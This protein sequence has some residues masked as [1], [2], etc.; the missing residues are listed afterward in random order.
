MLVRRNCTAAIC[1]ALLV[2]L[3]PLS[4]ALAGDRAHAGGFF[5]RLSG[6]VG[7]ASTELEYSGVK[8]KIE[9]GTGDINLAIGGV[10]AKN[11]ALHGTVWGWITQD[12]DV[13]VGS[14]KGQANGDVNF[15]AIGIGLTYYFMPVNM[16]LSGSLGAGYLTVDNGNVSGS[17][18]AGPA[19]ELTL[20]K[21]WWVGT[22][23]GL[24][25]ALSAGVHSVKDGGTDPSNNNT[26][27]EQWQ[28][29]N[30]AVRF[31]ATY[32]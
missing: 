27:N 17:T 14:Q 22:S 9:G 12:P 31:T 11:L 18:D 32:N 20:G 19:F 1:A 4:Q 29:G 25:V 10:V 5:L 26:I 15:S 2:T 13:T 23:W 6:G 3:V 28:G 16:Y 30:V 21:E 8:T 24:G 7:G